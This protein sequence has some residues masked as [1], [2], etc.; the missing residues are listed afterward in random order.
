M[1]LD[2]INNINNRCKNNWRFD[3]DYYMKKKKK[4]LVKK[5]NIDDE[6]YW[7]FTLSY[8]YQNQIILHI[9][10]YYINK[11]KSYTFCEG[12]GTSNILFKRRATRKNINNLIEFT[13][14]LTDDE[15]LKINKIREINHKS[16][17]KVWN[18]N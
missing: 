1:T 12:I 13:K 3:K 9:N 8:N 10:K 15:L 16:T 4:G 18:K 7:N 17:F 2:E 11:E 14:V 5:I 6:S